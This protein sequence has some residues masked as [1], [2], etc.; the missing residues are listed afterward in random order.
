MNKN[1]VSLGSDC[2]CAYTARDANKRAF[3]LPFDWVVTYNGVTD[4]IK[5]EFINFLPKLEN[6]TLF[7]SLS[8]TYF[9]H[10][11]FPDDYDKMNRRIERF[12]NLLKN[13]IDEIIFIRHGHHSHHHE[14]TEEL[15]WNLKND[16]TDSEEL[17]VHL[18]EKYPKLNF[19]IIVVLSCWKCFN[20]DNVYHSENIKIYNIATHSNKKKDKLIPQIYNEI[21]ENELV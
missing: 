20:I 5:D 3:A 6:T 15:N 10:N 16:I 18:K 1:Y 4:I 12:M 13:E 11:K 2:F 7:N 9:I 14:E 17:Y 19:K 8:K 21:F